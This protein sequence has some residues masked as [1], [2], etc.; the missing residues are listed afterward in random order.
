MGFSM[1]SRANKHSLDW[2]LEGMRETSR[3]LDEAG[4]FMPASARI[5]VS[6]G[7]RNFSKLPRVAWR[8]YL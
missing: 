1:L 2:G 7:H 6:R 5:G 8:W 4:W 3:L